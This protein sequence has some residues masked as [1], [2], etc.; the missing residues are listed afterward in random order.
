V[1][2]V[3]AIIP[4]RG[5]SKRIPRKTIRAF[6]DKPMI[7]HSIDTAMASGLFDRIVVSTDNLEI[8]EIAR[9]H[10]GEVP[11]MRDPSLADDQ[12]GLEPVVMDALDRLEATGCRPDFACCLFATAPMLTAEQLQEGFAR[13]RDAGATSCMPVVRFDSP[14]ARALH[15]TDGERLEMFY[16]EHLLTR[17]QDLPE[18]YFD[19]GQFYWIDVKRC[20]A[21]GGFYW[22]DTVPLVLP[23]WS[24]VDIDTEEDW[25]RAEVIHRLQAGEA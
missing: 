2:D 14:I 11:F 7:A 5:G 19:A 12:T 3:V 20:R 6:A 13:L 16:P 10:G 21:A 8:A 22:K 4:A 17:S 23:S 1:K 25:K 15:I 24:V 9:A 18:A